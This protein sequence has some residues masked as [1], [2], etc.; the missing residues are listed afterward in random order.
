MVKITSIFNYPKG[1]IMSLLEESYKPFH[2]QYPEYFNDNKKSFFECDSIF[3][4]NPEIANK[5]SFISEYEGNVVGMCCWDPRNFPIGIIG[6]NCILPTFQ[7]K[8][9]GKE[10]MS[11]ALGILKEKG[12]KVVQVST[13]LMNFF[14]PAQ[15]MYSGVGFKKVR[16]DLVNQVPRLHENIYYETLL[17]NE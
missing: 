1:T 6:H 11:I 7:C 12:F 2:Q 14:I 9:L 15:R 8:G 3:Y 13:G 4:N 10:Q 17:D 16:Q 5:C